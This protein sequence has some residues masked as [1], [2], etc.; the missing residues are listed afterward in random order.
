MTRLWLVGAMG[1]GKTSAGR[2]AAAALGV[3][4]WDTDEIVEATAGTTVAAIWAE[5]GEEGFRA[6]EKAVV[7]RLSGEVGVIATG[8]G[9]VLDPANRETKTGTVAWLKARPETVATRIESTGRPLLAGASVEESITAILRERE[10][11]YESV[12][13]DVVDTDG[14]DPN[15]VADLV[16]RLWVE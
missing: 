5:E 7:S 3:P 8:G 13:T 2:L 10:H 15:T 12:A 1:T 14:R 4:F 6:R 16:A 9:V 11:L